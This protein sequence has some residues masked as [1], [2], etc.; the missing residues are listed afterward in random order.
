[1]ELRYLKIEHYGPFEKYEVIFPENSKSILLTGRNN[2]G[3][4]NIISALKLLNSSSRVIGKRK[5][6]IVL[7]EGIFYRL[8]TQD[9]EGL[10]IKK[11]IYN[12][13]NEIG[14]IVGVFN[15]GLSISVYINPTSELIYTSYEGSIAKDIDGIFGVFPPL[16]QLNENEEL[17]KNNTHLRASMNTNLAPRHIRNHL[18][19]FISKEDY[20]LIKEIVNNTWKG[21]QLLD[22]EYRF[23]TNRLHWYFSENRYDREISWAGQGFQVWVQIITHLVRLKETSIL[24]LDEP[25]INLHPEKQHDLIKVIE[26]YYKGGVI[27]ATHSTELMNNVNIDHIIHVKKD[28]TRPT[29]K[30]AKDR[31]YLESIRSEIGSNFNL[32]ASQ[33]ENFDFV[34]FTEDKSDF[35][36]ISKIA[37]LNNKQVMAFNI[38]IFG[39]KQYKTCIYFKQ[40][41]DLLMGNNGVKFTLLLDRDYYPNEQLDNI[42]LELANE[43]IKTVFTPGKEIENIFL[44]EELFSAI[45]PQSSQLD[46]NIFLNETIENLYYDCLGSYQKL[47]K[48]YYKKYDDKT[49]IMKYIPEFDSIWNDKTGRLNKVAGKEMLRRIREYSQINYKKTLTEDYLLTELLKLQDPETKYL[50]QEIFI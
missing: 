24:I 3:K 25:E 14:K 23:D 10:Q 5:Q 1:M 32:I 9:I 28:A 49:I 45:F 38:P 12:Y 15:S 17:L 6:M 48:E 39:F 21:I 34:I 16:G 11:L 44:K 26:Q 37:L 41:Y 46:F 43:G 31:L 42:R 40:A 27:I 36:T 4:S 22:W 8:L 47:H 29:I 35:D 19:H 7:E 30:H 18:Y 20:E 33:F 2:E 50:L 13:S